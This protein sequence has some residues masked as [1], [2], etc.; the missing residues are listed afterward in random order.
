MTVY[1]LRQ[2]TR[3]VQISKHLPQSIIKSNSE[4]KILSAYPLIIVFISTEPS[5]LTTNME[6]ER[7]RRRGREKGSKYT[8]ISEVSP[9]IGRGAGLSTPQRAPGNSI[10][11]G[12][13]VILSSML[14]NA[15]EVPASFNP[16]ENPTALHAPPSSMGQSPLHR[17]GHIHTAGKRWISLRLHHHCCYWR[18]GRGGGDHRKEW[19]SCVQVLSSSPDQAETD[20][21]LCCSAGLPPRLLVL[22]S[23]I[24]CLREQSKGGN[25]STLL[26]GLTETLASTSH[27]EQG[28]HCW[29]DQ[30]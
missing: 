16:T 30:L 25:D 23:L 17:P 12:I 10:N 4:T 6:G 3:P 19:E 27:K 2:H 18:G 29:W 11:S 9:G 26:F 28:Q 21:H 8:L 1:S 15:I 14:L 7:E 20:S 5:P 24:F 13:T 22:M